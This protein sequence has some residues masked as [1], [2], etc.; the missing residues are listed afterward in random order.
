MRHHR[1]N[2]WFQLSPIDSWVFGDGRPNNAGED[3][4]D[5]GCIFPPSP[6]TVVGAIRAA[7]ARALGWS[8][9]GDWE[10]GIKRVLGDGWSDLGPLQFM[11]PFLGNERGPLFPAPFHLMGEVEPSGDW[12]PADLL[13]V[14]DSVVTSHYGGKSIHLPRLARLTGGDVIR[15]VEAKGV[16][17]TTRGLRAVLNGVLPR[18]DDCL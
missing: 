2:R 17:L 4:S 14:G 13:E 16:W 11:G 10:V 9:M 15:L 3:Q 18:P 8:G 6:L 12:R 5:L 7:A 1:R